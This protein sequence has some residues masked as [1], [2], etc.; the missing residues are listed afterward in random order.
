[1]R[2]VWR[3][4]HHQHALPNRAPEVETVTTETVTILEQTVDELDVAAVI[5]AVNKL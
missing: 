4:K 3:T 2:V 1:V 5:R